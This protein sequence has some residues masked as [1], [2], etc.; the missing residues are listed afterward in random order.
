MS[1]D[2]NSN[3]SFYQELLKKF[4][5]KYNYLSELF[6]SINSKMKYTVSTIFSLYCLRLHKNTKFHKDIESFNIL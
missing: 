4:C 5:K 2:I 6:M 3:K 1:R